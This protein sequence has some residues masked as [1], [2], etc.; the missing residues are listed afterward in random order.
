MK[1]RVIKSAVFFFSVFIVFACAQN[2][3]AGFGISPPY[4][5]TIK[6]IFPGS[7]YEQTITLLRSSAD[8]DLEAIVKV[9]APEIADWISIDKGDVFDLPKNEL[10]IPMVVLIDVPSSAEIGNYQGYINIQVSPKGQGTGGGVAIALGAR[11]DVDLNI[12][13]EA[14][15]DFTIRKFDIPDI[16]MLSKPWSYPI[17]SRF[18]YKV[19]AEITVKNTGNVK[20][21][22]TKATLEVYDLNKEILLEAGTDKKIPKVEPFETKTVIAAF[23]TKLSQGQ[24]WGKIRV[25]KDDEVVYKDETIFLVNDPGTLGTKLGILPW[26]MLGGMILLAILFILG[27]IKIKIW[28][29]VYKV[30]YVLSWPLRY[31]FSVLSRIWQAIKRKFWEKMHQKAIKYQKE[32]QVDKNNDKK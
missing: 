13:K 32:I 27:L 17:F 31:L 14:F 10:K 29:Y 12:T 7:H 28:R 25:Y 20:V 1:L 24:Y 18:F 9:N 21:A 6:P 23:P 2:A 4:V 26:L 11:V 16:E 22:P 30:I 19:K 15:L 5:K 3:Q 8:E